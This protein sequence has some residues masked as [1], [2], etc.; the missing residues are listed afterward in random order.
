MDDNGPMEVVY[1]EVNAAGRQGSWQ[2]GGVQGGRA[3]Q[4][5][6]NPGGAA[7]PWPAPTGSYASLK[8]SDN[9]FET[10]F[11]QSKDSPL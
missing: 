10:K 7:D 9:I 8:M 4:D 1:P 6:T 2:S 11:V 5:S 3:E